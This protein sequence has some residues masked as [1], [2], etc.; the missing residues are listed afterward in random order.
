LTAN[1]RTILG[2]QGRLATLSGDPGGALWAT[3]SPRTS[4]TPRWMPP[5]D[6]NAPFC[7]AYRSKNRDLKILSTQQCFAL[8]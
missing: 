6:I 3:A 4:E 5:H 8:R 7:G 2:A 1:S